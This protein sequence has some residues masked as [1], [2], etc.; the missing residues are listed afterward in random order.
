MAITPFENS[1][2]E[3]LISD[4]I[5]DIYYSELNIS[6]RL[7][8]LRKMT[9]LITRRFL[10]LGLGEKMELG[11]ITSPEKNPKYKTTERL[12]NVDKLL[13]KDFESTVNKLREI[14]NKYSHTQNHKI[15]NL[16]EWVEAENLIWDLFSYLFV[17]YF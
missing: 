14:G 11:D 10:N 13:R 3:I 2:Y 15:S 4:L 16:E 9:E 8:L 5:F 6:S 1:D 17:Q 12:N 7:V